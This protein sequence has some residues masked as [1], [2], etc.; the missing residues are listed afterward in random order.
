MKFTADTHC[1]VWY[2]TGNA[3][4]SPRGRRMFDE[5]S[6]SG[7][8]VISAV[9]VAELLYLSRKVSLPF[10]FDKTLALL[11]KEE[12]FEIHPL[13][14]EIIE[15]AVP[16]KHLEMHDALIVATSLQLEIPLMTTDNEIINSG[17]VEVIRP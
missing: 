8:I 4:L 6:R 12:R 2:L 15:T 10:S 5:Q 11:K 13:T 7:E 3:R 9:V 1:L 17:L 14:V 16:L